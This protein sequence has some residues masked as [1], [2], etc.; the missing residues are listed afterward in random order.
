[1]QME[2]KFRTFRNTYRI[3]YICLEGN[4]IGVDGIM[5][6]RTC[7]QITLITLFASPNNMI[8]SVEIKSQKSILN[9]CFYLNT[10]PN[11]LA[12]LRA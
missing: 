4:N 1:M 2:A 3:F 5:A 8:P 6:L 10:K 11:D 12:G 7:S 9:G